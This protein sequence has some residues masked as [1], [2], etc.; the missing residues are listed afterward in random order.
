MKPCVSP[1]STARPTLVMGR[2]PIS[3]FRP[4]LQNL[5]LGHPG[6]AQRRIDVQ[7]IGRNAVAHPR[8]SLSRRF[9]AT[10]SKSLYEV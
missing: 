7:R 10:I 2:L 3:A 8:G 4:L 9:A 6:A 5:G 1:F